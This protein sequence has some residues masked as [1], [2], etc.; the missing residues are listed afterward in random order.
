[1]RRLPLLLLMGVLLEGQALSKC[2][3]RVIHIEGTIEGASSD[4]LRIGVQVTPEPNWEPQPEMAIRSGR[5]AGTVLFDGTKSEG[6]VR[7][8]CSRVPET[9]DLILLRNGQELSRLRLVIAK[10]FVKDKLGDY[11]LRSPIMLHLQ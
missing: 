5:F 4:G 10:D 8:D 7:D 3:N 11:K 1:M 9:M 2:A 6:H